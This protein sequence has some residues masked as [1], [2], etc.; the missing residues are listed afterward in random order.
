MILITRSCFS[1]KIV[2]IE[3]WTLTRKNLHLRENTI[4]TIQVIDH[5]YIWP[6]IKVEEEKENKKNKYKKGNVDKKV[7]KEIIE[8][9]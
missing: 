9:K 7:K 8:E 3:I 4:S 2:S 1:L 6:C 5:E